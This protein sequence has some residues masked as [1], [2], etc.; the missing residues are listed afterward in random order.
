MSKMGNVV[1]GLG[2]RDLAILVGINA[3]DL[4]ADS[5]VFS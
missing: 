3:N 4:T 2:D 1:V 5:F